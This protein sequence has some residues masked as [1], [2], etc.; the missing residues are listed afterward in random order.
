[1]KNKKIARRAAKRIVL[2]TAFAGI[3]LSSAYLVYDLLWV[4]Y[5]FEK[6]S[7][8]TV[9]DEAV[10]AQ[11]DGNTDKISEKYQKIKEEYPDF[12][13]RIIAPELEMDFPV[14]QCKNNSYY[15]KHTIDGRV[16][17]HG[18]LFADFRNDMTELDDNTVIYG[19]NMKDCTQFGMLNVYKSVEKYRLC[20]VI[21]FNTLY[22]DYRWKV[23]ASFLI[24]T[25]PEDD[26]GR[27]FE[28]TKTDFSSEKEFEDFYKEVAERSYI[29]TVVD[30]KYGDKILT[31]STCST[32][33]DDSRLVVMA[34]LVRDGESENVDTASARQNS[35]QRF[36]S[37]F[38]ND[39]QHITKSNI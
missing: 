9:C 15:L 18:T 27:V 6:L 23:F 26:G 5:H 30:V 13:G 28:Y 38:K 11:T 29:K 14:V 24:N 32:L 2:I 4:P 8:T 17:K 35:E 16:D 21:T 20:P 7:E 10:Q 33:F 12:C 36:P 34:R 19:H 22:H 25:K 39:K 1:M 31:M 3:I 37:A